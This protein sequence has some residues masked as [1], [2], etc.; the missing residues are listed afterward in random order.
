MNRSRKKHWGMDE[1]AFCMLLNLSQLLHI[2][3]SLGIILPVVMWITEKHRSSTI[4]AHGKN[5]LNWQI[6]AV[7]YAGIASIIASIIGIKLLNVAMALGVITLV[8]A[9]LGAVKANEGKVWKYPLAI[10]FFS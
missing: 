2:I 5:V 1:R 3:P 7:I 4:D 9:I 8:F 6:S 10:P